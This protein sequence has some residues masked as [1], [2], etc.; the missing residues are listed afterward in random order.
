MTTSSP[1]TASPTTTCTAPTSIVSWPSG[2]APAVPR[3]GPAPGRAR[4]RGGERRRAALRR[5]VERHR[6]RRRRG[7]RHPLRRASGV[8]RRG[9]APLLGQLG[10]ARPGAGRAGRRPAAAGR[11]HR[12]DGSGPPLRLLLRGRRAVRQLGRRRPVGDV[13]AGVVDD[14][15]PA[16]RRPGR[17]RRLEP[18]RAPADHRGRR[19]QRPAPTSTAGRCTTAIRCPRWGDGPGHP[20]RRRR[21]PDAAVHGPGRLPGHR[22]RRRAGRLPA[23]AARPGPGA[24]PLRGPAP[25]ADRPRAA[26]RPPQRD[27]VPP[28][29]RPRAARP[30]PR[31]RRD[32]RRTAPCTATAGCSATTSTRRWQ[33]TRPPRLPPRVS[34]GRDRLGRRRVLRQPACGMS[35]GGCLDDSEA[36]G[37]L[38]HQD[39]LELEAAAVEQRSELGFGSLSSAQQQQHVKVHADGG[40]TVEGAF[41][42]DRLDQ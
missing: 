35:R 18:G 15:R 26:G 27:P 23:A 1:S 40:G 36:G 6:R 5:R 17:L 9:G 32:E 19:R 24:A 42:Q 20:A 16:G 37:G 41:G 30:R 38:G 29:R 39:S 14:P 13:D 33:Q 28:P 34:E 3:A 8:A 22:G 11:Q 21:P 2:V 7:R 31:P 25:R 10:V 4:G 12:G